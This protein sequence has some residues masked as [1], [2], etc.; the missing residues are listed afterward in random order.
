M[1]CDNTI[2]RNNILEECL[3]TNGLVSER[4]F[5]KAFPQVYVE[6][7]SIKFPNNFTFKQKLYHYLH[8]DDNMKLG[9]YPICGR[10]CNFTGK[11]K[12]GYHTYCSCKCK[13]NAPVI[14]EKSRQTKLE[15]YG[16][17]NYNNRES[18][19]KTNMER[20]GVTAPTQNKEICDKIK[21]TKLEKY[22]DE[23]YNNAQ[24]QKLTMSQKTDAERMVIRK[25]YSEGYHKKSEDERKIIKN[26]IMSSKHNRMICDNEHLLGY[27]TCGNWICKCTHEECNKCSNKKYTINPKN[28]YARKKLGI[29][30]CTVI[31]PINANVSWCENEVV[32]FIKEIYDGKIIQ[33][34]RTELD[35]KELDI[36]MPDKNIA[37]EFNGVYWHSDLYKDKNYHFDKTMSCMKKGIQ[38][39]H[40]WEDDWY[41]KQDIIKDIIKCK[42]HKQHHKINA[43]DC[44]V[45]EI[46]TKIAKEFCETYHIH[47]YA[48]S[49]IKLGLYKHD[50]LVMVATFGY[51]RKISGGEKKE[52]IWEL[53]RMCSLFDVNVRGGI[54]KLLNYFITLCNPSEIITFADMSISNGNVY[55]KIGFEKLYIVPPT[56][57]W[58]IGN[59]RY[60]RYRFQKSNLIECKENPNLTEDEVMRTR[61]YFKCWDSG[62]IKYIWQQKQ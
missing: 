5:K 17:C 31:N 20:Y 47:G 21:H 3:N 36:F 46:D 57:Y 42:L 13:S 56:Y 38:L 44:E 24:K 19:K 62:K 29:E 10:R 2:D 23:N 12:K 60:P 48:N 55:E 58:C 6:L 32:D 53:Y 14:Q 51:G 28:Y 27:D 37:I 9:V 25:H 39:L 59:K 1:D 26:K 43:R 33:S 61:G 54:S 18:A 11:F 52:N 15:R 30:I 49:I 45:R 22:G 8:N 35:G 41:T 7:Q 40:I 4:R 34:C 50:D 16:D